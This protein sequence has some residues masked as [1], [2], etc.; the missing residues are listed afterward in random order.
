MEDGEVIVKRY[1]GDGG[2]DDKCYLTFLS[3][4]DLSPKVLHENLNLPPHIEDYYTV[5]RKCG[6]FLHFDDFEGNIALFN[7]TT[8]ELKLLPRPKLDTPQD[9]V[10]F[11]GSGL[12]YDSKSDDYKVVRDFMEW[13]VDEADVVIG[14]RRHTELYS[15]KSGYWKDIPSPAADIGG[16]TGVYLNG[17]CYWIGFDRDCCILSFDFTKESFD[18]LHELPPEEGLDLATNLVVCRGSLGAIGYEKK[19]GISKSF[20]L[21]IWEASSWSKLFDLVL[22]G[23][24]RPLGLK[25]G[26]F[27]FVEGCK[28]SDDELSQLLVYDCVTKEQKELNIYDYPGQMEVISYDD[29]LS[30]ARP[31]PHRKKR[32]LGVA[33][34]GFGLKTMMM[35]KNRV[36]TKR[37]KV[38]H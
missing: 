23:V 5:I 26:R 27:L 15:L 22:Y 6:V 10:V 28:R 33:K 29:T 24:E 19:S 37:K 31:M 11:N 25:D 32:A 36:R 35:M 21:W 12:G 8:K 3:P 16:D 17:R 30:D 1:R 4:Q 13:Y 38:A 18:G 2:H 20:V 9:T 7:L 14:T 34:I